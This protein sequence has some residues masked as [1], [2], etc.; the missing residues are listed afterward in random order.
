MEQRLTATEARVH[1]GELLRRVAEDGET[2]IVERAGSAAAVV[3]P[4]ETYE[5]WKAGEPPV[6]W[7]EALDMARKV[8][9]SMA[10]RVSGRGFPSPDE[11][12]RQAREE[13]DD[14]LVGRR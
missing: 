11:V 1:F 10:G 3:L 2:V 6:G 13:R 9:K 8:R 14:E 5:R 7:R 12:L 4:I